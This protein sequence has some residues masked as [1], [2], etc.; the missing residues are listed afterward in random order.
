MTP[1]GLSS[2][3]TNTFCGFVTPVER[4]W[5]GRFPARGGWRLGTVKRSTRRKKG[6]PSR[7]RPWTVPVFDTPPRA[8]CKDCGK[9]TEPMVKGKPVFRW[10]DMYI[11]RDDLWAEAGMDGWA[12]GFLCT[13]CLEKRLDRK[14]RQED[15]LSWPVGVDE[16]GRWSWAAK[17]EY[18]EKVVREDREREAEGE[19]R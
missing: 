18:V 16:Q 14:L 15:Y 11:L 12:S 1:D 2:R 5:D 4:A 17:R 3:L 9:E 19:R 13:P 7:P 6:G 10:W 8:P